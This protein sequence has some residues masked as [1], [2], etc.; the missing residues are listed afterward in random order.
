MRRS[1]TLEKLRAGKLVRICGLGHYIPSFVRHA[2]HFDFDCIWLDLEHRAMSDNDV[3]SL[4]G[5]CHQFDIDCMVRSPTLERVR[6][7]RYLEDGAAGLM[8]PHVT[9]QEDA[10]RLVEAAKFPPL[11]NRGLDGAGL[12]TDYFLQGGPGYTDDANRETFVVA[13]IE[14]PQAVE[15]VKAIAAVEGIDAV[16]IGPADLGL[17]LQHH[18]GSMTMEEATQLVADAA[19]ANGKPWGRPAGTPELLQEL[20]DQGARLLAQGGEFLA[21]LQML[22]AASKV[23]TGVEPVE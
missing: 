5:F 3:R 2:A 9:T 6:I 22:E 12:D 13:Q 15:N 7:Y 18:A 14:S 21:I 20:Y 4:L 16:F 1:K 23:F 10:E 17:R 8:F 19:A 11:G